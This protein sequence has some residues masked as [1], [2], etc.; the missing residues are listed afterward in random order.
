MFAM[1]C[2]GR[3]LADGQWGSSM[4]TLDPPYPTDD[5]YFPEGQTLQ[6]TNETL[7]IC[8]WGV[9]GIN[10]TAPNGND[11]LN[12][13]EYF[14]YSQYILRT[15]G[16]QLIAPALDSWQVGNLS[17]DKYSYFGIGNTYNAKQLYFY[18]S[19]NQYKNYNEYIWTTA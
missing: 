15:T 17:D 14:F 3:F 16:G 8:T 19:T 9:E 6:H 2:S 13:P 11:R 4:I 7:S 1:N 18:Y 10:C 5:Y 12:A